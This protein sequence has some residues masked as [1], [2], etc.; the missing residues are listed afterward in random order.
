[1][2]NKSLENVD[3][4]WAWQP[5]VPTNDQPWTKRLAAHLFRRAAFGANVAQIAEAIK[6]SPEEVVGKLVRGGTETAEDQRASDTLAQTLLAT[7]DPRQLAAWWVYVLLHSRQPLTERLT[8][9]WHGH[10]ATSADKVTDAAAMLD[11]NRL[12]RRHALGDFRQLVQ[13][14]SR[15]AA[16]LIYLDSVTNRK[17][18]PNENY[19]R[20]LMELFCLGE[21]NYTEKDVQELARCFTGWEIKQGRFRF[22]RFQHDD[23]EKNI[24]GKSNQFPDGSAIDWI[25]DQPQAPRF[26]VSKLFRAL[27]C[28][29]PAPPTALIDPLARDLSEHGWKIGRVVERMLGS[30]LFF[31]GFAVGRKVRSPVDLA[32]GLLRSL[33][34]STNTQQ[35]TNDLQQ[36][37]QGLFYP[38]NVKGWDGG[39]S[40]INSSTILSRTNLV[41][42][43][44]ADEKTRFGGGKLPEYLAKLEIN[45]PTKLVD[46][47]DELLVVFPLSAPV[48]ERLLQL[49]KDVKDRSR[50]SAELLLALVALPEFQLG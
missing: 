37:G 42:R 44:L 21:G 12:L 41:G 11:Q 7:G 35:L 39:R 48:R 43:L 28:D 23:G 29:E 24:L 27:I 46:M 9:V 20:E 36:V 32:V 34:G 38:P 6:Q 22:N 30:Q 13:D 1:M 2:N 45:S 31:S 26:I 40:W 14:I 49:E 3:P 16:M 19:A 15:D 10:F 25:V 4:A 18:H 8:V 5:Y 47:L 17:L 33:D 50:A